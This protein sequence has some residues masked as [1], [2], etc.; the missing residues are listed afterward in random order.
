MALWLVSGPTRA[1]EHGRQALRPAPRLTDQHA[2]ARGARATGARGTA[3][4]LLVEAPRRG[5]PGAPGALPGT[6]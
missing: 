4:P 2:M 1:S 3:R 5:A 6:R